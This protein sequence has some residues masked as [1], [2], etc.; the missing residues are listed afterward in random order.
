[1]TSQLIATAPDP[2]SAAASSS[3]SFRRASSANLRAPLGQPHRD[4]PTE[5][6]RRADDHRSH[7]VSL[8]CLSSRASRRSRFA[9]S[10][11][12]VNERSSA[13]SAKSIVASTARSRCRLMIRFVSSTA[14][15]GSFAIRRGARD[16]LVEHLVV[17]AHVVHQ[18]DLGRARGR[19]AVAGEDVLLGELQ[20]GQQRPGDRAAVGR[21]PD[22][23]RRAGSARCA[24]SAMKTMSDRATRLQPRPT[25]GPLTAAM[26]GT[27]HAAIPVTMRL[28]STSVCSPQRAV[29]GQ[30]VEVPEVPAGREGAPVA[31]Q[32]RDPGVLVGVEL[33]EQA[34]QRWC[35]SWFVA[36]S[37]SG[38]FRRTIR[39]G[40]SC[41]D[42]DHVGEVV[43]VH[44]VGSPRM[45][46]ATRLRW[47]CA[48]PPMTLWARL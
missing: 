43:A 3:S 23:A 36:L 33:G 44:A 39:I 30:L 28:P 13:A 27:R 17:G 9:R 4:A 14:R 31:G 11:G 22:R 18:A 38:R 6:G 7:R 24:L 46:R 25:A 35:S 32:D 16:R 1:M 40:P 21:R 37:S 34:R 41:L 42:L 47:I 2:A 29:L 20:A 26:I 10:S 45:R 8:S 48:V 19:D 5:A 12:D 15:R